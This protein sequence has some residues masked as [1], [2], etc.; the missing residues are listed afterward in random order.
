MS[1]YT[2][3]HF[4]R[5]GPPPILMGADLARFVAGFASLGIDREDGPL[6]LRIK[7]GRAIDQDERPTD[8]DE[9]I[10][11][12][13]TLAVAHRIAFDAEADDLPTF[14]RLAEEM[15]KLGGPIY[16]ADLDLGRVAEPVRSLARREPS[17]E[18]EVTLSLGHWGLQ[19]G[20][21][22]S[23][24]LDSDA[25]FLVGWIAVTLHGHGYLHPWGFPDLIDRVESAP[26]IRELMNLCRRTW[27]VEPHKPP[28]S[29][30]KLR[31][32]MRGLWPYPRIDLP[33]D[34]YWGLAE[35]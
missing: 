5:P 13:G 9:P 14:A 15:A 16:R 6:G 19:I 21:V 22:M 27:P 26:G 29:V 31:K 4:Y 32:S 1:V 17:A 30:A 23:Y 25:E 10:M 18:N 2:S 11:D 33:G 34:W 35:G 20:P 24:S 7:F 3:L 28:R 12:G 8:S